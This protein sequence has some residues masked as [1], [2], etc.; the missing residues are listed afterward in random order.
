M[1]RPA[2]RNIDPLVFGSCLSAIPSGMWR[3]RGNDVV[4]LHLLDEGRGDWPSAAVFTGSQPR[5]KPVFGVVSPPP[6]PPP[7][8]WRAGGEA[9]LLTCSVYFCSRD[10]VANFF[11]YVHSP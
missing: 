10:D 2:S 11:T 3:G 9:V 8:A 5:T 6:P 1:K 7:P 4:R